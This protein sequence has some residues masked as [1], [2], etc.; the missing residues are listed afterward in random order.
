MA[1]QRGTYSRNA[2]YKATLG[3]LQYLARYTEYRSAALTE[4]D[5]RNK[6]GIRNNAPNAESIRRTDY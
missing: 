3:Q 2:I 6:D 5:R 1:S 4:L